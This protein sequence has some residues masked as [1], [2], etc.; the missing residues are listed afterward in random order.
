MI[1]ENHRVAIG[2][3]AAQ[4]CKQLLQTREKHIDQSRERENPAQINKTL[5]RWPINSG[6]LGSAK[7][8]APNAQHTPPN[9]RYDAFPPANYADF[10]NY[11]QWV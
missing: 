4:C 3:L 11:G 7:P 8:K 6:N 9:M 10:S 1:C 2:L 5:E